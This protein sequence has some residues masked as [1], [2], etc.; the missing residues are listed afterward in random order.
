MGTMKLS[1]RARSQKVAACIKENIEQTIR[2]IAT[3]TGISKSSVHRHRQAIKRR[4]QYPESS[5][6]ETEAGGQWLVRLVFGLVYYFGIKQGV[7]AESLSEFIGAVH[8]DTH[9]A[10]SASG[11]RQLKA[12]VNQAVINYERAQAEHCVPDEGQGICVGADETFFGLPVL[13]LLKLSSGFILV[14]PN[15]RTAPTQLGW[16]RSPSGGRAAHG[17]VTFRLNI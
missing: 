12:R 10:S 13:V 2:R 17:R 4:H 15:A 14:K 3:T 9:V 5:F 16:S 8:L 7:G 6:W 1:I 11:L